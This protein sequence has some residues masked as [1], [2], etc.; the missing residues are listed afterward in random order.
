MIKDEIRNSELYKDLDPVASSLGFCIVD[1]EV[2]RKT[3]EIKVSLTIFSKTKDVTID[4][5]ENFHRSVEPRLELRYDRDLLSMEV[6]TPGL[7]RTF[8]DFN[9]FDV[10]AGKTVRLYSKNKGSWVVGENKGL[11]DNKVVL[12]NYKVEDSSET[13]ETLVL[14]KEDVQKAKL[15]YVWETAEDKKRKNQLAQKNN[16]RNNRVGDSADV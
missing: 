2:Y 10:F 8:K 12:L 9:E 6:S 3:D 16:R 1:A 7:Q 4:D 13:G 5:C 14:D 11:C 15:E